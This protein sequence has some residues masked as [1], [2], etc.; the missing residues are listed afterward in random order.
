MKFKTSSKEKWLKKSNVL[1]V[2]SSLT[3]LLN[4]ENVISFSVNIASFNYKKVVQIS[5]FLITTKSSVTI[6]KKANLR[7]MLT[8]DIHKSPKTPSLMLMQEL[9]KK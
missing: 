5:Q 6:V 3:S 9:N 4:A 2:F 8:L 7:N 1:F